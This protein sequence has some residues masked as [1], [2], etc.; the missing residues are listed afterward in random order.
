[1]PNDVR[2]MTDSRIAALKGR[3]RECM[4]SI[5]I[6]PYADVLEEGYRALDELC[7]EVERLK[8][9]LAK[10]P[11]E[12]EVTVMRE[13]CEASNVITADEELSS[14]YHFK[15]QLKAAVFEMSRDAYRAMK[16]EGN[17]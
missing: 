15:N 13:L 8:A 14:R 12:A 1:M 9:E 6:G 17:G 2:E 3:V 4:N 11:S 7:T 16:G 5:L 10:R